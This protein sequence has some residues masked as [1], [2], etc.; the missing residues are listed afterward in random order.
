VGCV[1]L[2]QLLPC[3]ACNSNFKLATKISQLCLTGP[4]VVGY[5]RLRVFTV[6]NPR[7]YE[8]E[9]VTKSK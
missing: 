2:E 6:P 5:C 3:T 9:E 1:E 7:G 4:A 8:S